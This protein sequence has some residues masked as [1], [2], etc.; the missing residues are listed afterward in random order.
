LGIAMIV[1]NRSHQFG[2]SHFGVVKC[3]TFQCTVC[4]APEGMFKGSST[5]FKAF[6]GDE[7][8][9]SKN[10]VTVAKALL[11]PTMSK[12]KRTLIHR[13]LLNHLDV[14]GIKG[15][16]LSKA[17]DE[18][19]EAG[20]VGGVV[21]H[22]INKAHELW[23]SDAAKATRTSVLHKFDLGAYK[24]DNKIADFA[25]LVEFSPLE[26]AAIKRT[27]KSEKIYNAP[28]VD[29]LGRSWQ[30]MLSTVNGQIW[31]IAVLISRSNEQEAAPIAIQA[32]QY[33]EQVLGSPSE[34]TPQLSV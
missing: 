16:D 15:Y 19:L 3:P 20:R 29:F 31:K 24:L 2:L 13:S 4:T 34:E 14:C 30:L 23:T 28:S 10:L 18:V 27:F 17:I 11:L 1:S 5:I 32:H 33:C 8:N 22:S 21:V 26:Y 9:H 7:W 6:D 12:K 25:G